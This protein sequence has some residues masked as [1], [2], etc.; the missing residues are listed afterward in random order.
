MIYIWCS[1]FLLLGIGIGYLLSHADYGRRCNNGW[2]IW[3]CDDDT[4]DGTDDAIESFTE[5]I[6]CGHI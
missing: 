5:W 2:I 3:K 6:T 1:I 4:W